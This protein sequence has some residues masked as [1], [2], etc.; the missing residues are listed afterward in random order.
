MELLALTSLPVVLE[1][2]AVGAQA[3]HSTHRRQTR[4]GTSGIVDAARTRVSLTLARVIVGGQGCVRQTL[5]GT[6]VSSHEISAGVLTRTPPVVQ[7]TFVD[8]WWQQITRTFIR[9][10]QRCA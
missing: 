9:P 8:V 5:A 6:L 3:E 7:Q 4:V 1:D 2:E 10:V